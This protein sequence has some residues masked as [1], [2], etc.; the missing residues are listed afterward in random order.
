[1]EATL[2]QIEEG[3]ALLEFRNFI[4]LASLATH[5]PRIEL[6]EF[7]IPRI[8]SGVPSEVDRL[9]ALAD[10]TVNP[11]RYLIAGVKGTPVALLERPDA[12]HPFRLQRI[13]NH[14]TQ[15]QA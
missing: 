9:L 12:G 13:F 11:S 2:E 7:E 15:S 6:K 14:E 1:L 10:R 4:P 8:R 5:L 3:V